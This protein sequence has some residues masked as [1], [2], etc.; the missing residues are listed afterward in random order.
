MLFTSISFLYYFLPTIII[1]YFITPKKYRNYILLIFSIIFYM[2]GEPKYVILM[3]VEILVAYFGALLIDKYKSKEIFL[4][5]IIIHI[6]LLCVFKYTDLFIGTINS[7]FKTNISF[8]NITLPIGISFYTF[9]ILSYV[10][11]VYR[12]KV[13][14]QKNILK[15]ATYVSLFP[16][17]IA[18]PIVRYETICDE[19]DNRD[20]TIEKFSLGV[21]RFIIGLAKKVLIANM[22]GELCTKFSLVDERSVLFYWIFAISYMLQ[23]YFD[24]SAYSD[25]AIGL[26]KMFGFTFLENFNYPFISKSITEFWRRWHI[27]LS[28]WFKDY[29]YI[30]LGGSRKGTL[31]LVRNI[32]IVWFLTGIWH[33]AAYNFILWGLFIGVFLVIEKLWLSKYISKLPKVLRNIYVLFIIMISFI[34]FNAESINE[35]FF[36]IKGLFGLNKEVFINN[37]T[38]YYLKSYLIVLI[39]AIFGATPLFKNIIEKLKKSKCLNKIINILEPIFLVIL[40]LLVTAYLIDSSY[41]PFLYFRF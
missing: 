29:V 38:I 18:G 31:K 39:I 24:F 13:K 6:G 19:L 11:D 25:M 10:I 17:L 4:I 28:S 9:Q 26:G 21:R 30:P 15:L 33:G 40:L 3:L 27:S 5:T 41:N 32:L 20:E 16:Q 14:V 7:I 22:L 2:Y 1:L 35:A 36:N 23:V 37:Y 34:M 8:L 12:G